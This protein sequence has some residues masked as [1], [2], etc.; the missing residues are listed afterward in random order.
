VKLPT[1]DVRDLM[2]DVADPL[3]AA[4][5]AHYTAAE[6]QEKGEPF[7]EDD[8]LTPPPDEALTTVFDEVTGDAGELSGQRRELSLELVRLMLILDHMKYRSAVVERLHRL[9]PIGDSDLSSRIL[10]AVMRRFPREWSNWLNPLDVAAIS[11]DEGLQQ[12]VDSAAAA[13]WNKLL[14]DEPPSDEDVDAAVA[15]LARCAAN[16][17]VRKKVTA[18]VRTILAAPYNSDELVA[19]Q[20]R[21]LEQAAKFANA[22]IIDRRWLADIE[23]TAAEQTLRSDPPPPAAPQP[24]VPPNTAAPAQAT[25]TTDVP[26]AILSRVRA[27]ADLASPGE[28][29]EVI[30]AIAEGRWLSEAARADT[31]LLAASRAKTGGAEIGSPVAVEQLH[32]LVPHLGDA[33][34]EL[35][36]ESFSLAIAHFAEGPDAAWHLVEPLVDDELP[37]RTR[38]ALSEFAQRLSGPDRFALIEQALQ[39][40]ITHPV[41]R[42]FFEA[43]RLSESSAE[44]VAKRLGE[45]FSQANDEA[46][47]R[48]VLNVWQ[49]LGPIAE[50]AQQRLV[51]EVYVPLIEKGDAGLDL[52]VSYFRLV[53]DVHGVRPRVTAAFEKAAHV[54]EQQRR[55]DERLLEGNWKRKSLFGFGPSVDRE[56]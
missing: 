33:E 41:D 45:P 42:S 49:Q 2:R 38:N 15:A 54:E 9:A 10:A 48:G 36:D 19:S 30:A 50:A 43:A 3:K 34:R 44:T 39:R 27:A 37:P 28:L 25:T 13:L 26:G 24:G 29:K 8:L 31:Q 12:A 55:V 14:D 20:N 40:V 22:G 53:S 7:E 11:G 21:A 16:V 56:E 51:D 32:A 18:A 46:G 35:V 1:D 47:W 4:S 17:D 5:D 23:L 52:A 6:A